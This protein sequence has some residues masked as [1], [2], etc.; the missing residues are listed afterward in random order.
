MEIIMES[1]STKKA[2][3]E[4]MRSEA[5]KIYVIISKNKNHKKNALIL[6]LEMKK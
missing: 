4:F 3:L 6:N 1:L 5:E 2:L